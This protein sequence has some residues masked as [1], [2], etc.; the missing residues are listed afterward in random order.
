MHLEHNFNGR[1]FGK[2]P[3]LKKLNLREIIGVKGVYGTI[4]QT[5]I[6]RNLPAFESLPFKDYSA[7]TIAPSQVYYE[8]NA[9]IANILKVFRIDLFWRGSYLNHQDANTFGVKGSFGFTF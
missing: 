7:K 3:L 9:G 2:I 6:N 5:N 1:I 8:Y 4:S